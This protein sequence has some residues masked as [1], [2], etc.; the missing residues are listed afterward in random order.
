[1]EH[2]AAMRVEI[3]DDWCDTMRTAGDPALMKPPAT[4]VNT[5]FAAGAP[6]NVVNPE[7]VG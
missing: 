4:L 1:M 2:A 6:I 5:A 3:L 7:V